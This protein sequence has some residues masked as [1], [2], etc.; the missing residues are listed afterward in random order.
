[1][2]THV[3][4]LGVLN[5]VVGGCFLVG[6]MFLALVLG[7]TA[8]I[9]GAAA[10][11]EDAAIAIPILGIAGSALTIFLLPARL[12][13]AEPHHRVGPAD[14]QELGAYRRDRAGSDQPDQYSVRHDPR[15]LRPLGAPQ[16]GHRAALRRAG[17]GVADRLVPPATSAIPTTERPAAALAC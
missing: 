17:R 15:N 7:G 4:V 14:V 13:A 1:M 6:A 8:G 5:L 11:A 2:T 16:Q 9:V 3:K 10:E 12:R